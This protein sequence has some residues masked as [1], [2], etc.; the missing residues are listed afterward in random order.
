MRSL[1]II[2]A[3]SLGPMSGAAFEISK[4][5]KPSESDKA[6]CCCPTG[7]VCRCGCKAPK[8]TP[9]QPPTPTPVRQVCSC[10]DM[11][12]GPLPDG[13]FNVEPHRLIEILVVAQEMVP[14]TFSMRMTED[15]S[16]MHGPPPDL[17]YL[18]TII[19][20]A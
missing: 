3:C 17:P 19:L 8:S 12:Y 6:C 9:D 7:E 5:A 13:R 2:L 15:W 10:D 11:P 4:C 16:C 14:K 18:R 1:L 20:I